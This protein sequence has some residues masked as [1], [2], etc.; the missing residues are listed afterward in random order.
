MY[1]IR[2][3]LYTSISDIGINS[4]LEA[5]WIVVRVLIL[6]IDVILRNPSYLKIWIRQI[7]SPWWDWQ[8]A[9]L[10]DWLSRTFHGG[11]WNIFSPGIGWILPK[12]EKSTA[13]DWLLSVSRG[14]NWELPWNQTYITALSYWGVS[15]IPLNV[16]PLCQETPVFRTANE[17]F[18][19]LRY[20]P[21]A[22]HFGGNSYKRNFI[23]LSGYRVGCGPVVALT[24][25]EFLDTLTPPGVY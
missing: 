2:Y 19:S 23:W 17:I 10:Q 22:H 5:S 18:S 3:I 4:R 24:P 16:P 11:V 20:C 12:L 9:S 1:N 25:P 6:L 8:I 15:G 13:I 14:P 21:S 7:W